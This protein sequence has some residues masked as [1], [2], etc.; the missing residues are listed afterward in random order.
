MVHDTHIVRIDKKML[1][2]IYRQC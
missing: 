2:M 1:N